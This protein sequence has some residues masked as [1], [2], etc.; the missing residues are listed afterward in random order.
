V[1]GGQESCALSLGPCSE[2]ELKKKK[3][4]AKAEARRKKI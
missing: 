1:G 2:D 3:A 4:A